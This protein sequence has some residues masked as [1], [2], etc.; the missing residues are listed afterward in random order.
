MEKEMR[1][2][3]KRKFSEDDPSWQGRLVKAGIP[4][5]YW[6]TSI[7]KIKMPAVRE[8]VERQVEDTPQWM[9]VGRGFYL[10]GYLNSGKTSIASILAKDAIKRVE[11]ISWVCARDITAVMWQ[12]GERAEKMYERLLGCDLLVV[13]DLGAESQ[14]K[15]LNP[16]VGIAFEQLIRIPYDRERSVIVTSNVHWLDFIEAYSGDARPLVSVLSRLLTEFAVENE[17]WGGEIVE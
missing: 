1:R 15:A 7:E 14:T 12:K 6:E 3:R 11:T 9:G 2:V 10:H 13:D 16:N 5:R 17:Q 8:W 4:A